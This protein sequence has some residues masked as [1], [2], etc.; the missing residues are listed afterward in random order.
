MTNFWKEPFYADHTVEFVETVNQQE[1]LMS[2]LESVDLG[3]KE[4][5]KH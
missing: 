4:I 2:I 5:I 3:V 1:R